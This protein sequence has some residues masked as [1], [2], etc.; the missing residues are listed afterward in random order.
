[1]SLTDKDILQV[2][3]TVIAGLLILLT[4]QSFAFPST[5]LPSYTGIIPIN[6]TEISKAAH[7]LKSPFTNPIYTELYMM[8]PFALS[9]ILLL[10]NSNPFHTSEDHFWR[11][12]R[13]FSIILTATGFVGL[14]IVPMIIAIP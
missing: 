5:S 8:W 6:Q 9:A 7:F 14:M 11:A 2:D 1:M 12:I 13:F 4:I 3:A 10:L